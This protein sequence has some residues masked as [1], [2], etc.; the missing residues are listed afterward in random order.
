MSVFELMHRIIKYL[1]MYKGGNFLNLV[2]EYF[3]Y[4]EWNKKLNKLDKSGDFKEYSRYYSSINYRNKTVVDWGA[5]IGS[6]AIYFLSKGASKVYCYEVDKSKIKKFN[7]A[8]SMPEFRQYNLRNKIKYNIPN[9]K[10]DILKMDIEGS[11]AKVLSEEYLNYFSKFII[12]LHPQQ[13]S[14]KKFVYLSNILKKHGGHIYGEVFN[15][16][17]LAE[18]IYIK[19]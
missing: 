4:R 9:A 19:Q 10:G 7:I 1:K 17:S 14:A 2:I 5:D 8:K 12:A 15:S 13:I 6:S 3:R 16:K 18:V 11:E